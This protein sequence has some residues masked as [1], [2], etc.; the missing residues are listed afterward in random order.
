[1]DFGEL[2][3]DVDEKFV[4]PAGPFQFVPYGVFAGIQPRQV[5]RQGAFSASLHRRLRHPPRAAHSVDSDRRADQ[6]QHFRQLGRCCD[7][8]GFAVN[9]PLPQHR[10]S[11]LGPGADQTQRYCPAARP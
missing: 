8:V 3:Q 1:M 5:Q 11:R 2:G 6:T 10:A 9:G 7:L 4:V